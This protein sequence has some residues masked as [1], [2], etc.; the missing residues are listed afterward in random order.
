MPLYYESEATTNIGKWQLISQE[1]STCSNSTIETLEKDVKYVL[2]HS[3]T[4]H[5]FFYISIVDFQRVNACCAEG[6][7]KFSAWKHYYLFVKLK[8]FSFLE[9]ELELGGI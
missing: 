6:I 7:S 9:L 1:T 2:S 4:F 8:S 3:W 5:T